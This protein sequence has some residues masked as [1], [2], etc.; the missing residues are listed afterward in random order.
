MTRSAIAI[1]IALVCGRAGAQDVYFVPFDID[2]PIQVDAD[3]TDWQGMP[4]PIALS[5][6]ANVTYRKRVWSGAA[7]LSGVVRLAYVHDGLLLAAEVTDD[8]VLQPGAGE[9]MWRADHIMI[10]LDMAPTAEPERELPGEGQYQVAISPGNFDGE[11]GGDA[12]VAP[13]VWVYR[14]EGLEQTGGLA[15]SRRTEG[16]YVVEAYVPFALLGLPPVA[17][18]D[19]ATFEIAI[20]DSDDPEEAQQLMV[21][22]STE[23][24]AI[25]RAR[26]LPLV[27]GDGNGEGEPPTTSVPLADEIVLQQRETAQVSFDA[28]DL[29]EGR[30]PFLFFHARRNSDQVGGYSTKALE[31]AVNGTVVDSDRLS[32]GPD[33]VQ[34]KDGRMLTWVTPDGRLTLPWAAD[35]TSTQEHETYGLVETTAGEYELYIGGLLQAGENT[36]EFRNVCIEIEPERDILTIGDVAVRAKP[37]APGLALLRPAPTG[38]LPVR[39]P[40]TE[41]PKTYELARQDEAEIE[42]SV[43]GDSFVVGSHFSAPDGQWHEGSTEFFE[44]TR[45]VIEHDEW[46]EVQDTFRNLTGENLPVM[47]E[48]SCA[49]GDRA[50]GVWLAGAR[51]PIGVGQRRRGD[52]PSVFAATAESG[53]GIVPLSDVLRVHARQEARDGTVTL[54]DRSLYL[55]PGAEYTAE[56]AIVPVPTPDFYDFINQARRMLDVNF[57]LEWLFAFHFYLEAVYDWSDET[58]RSFIINKSTNFIVK[59]LYGAGRLEGGGVKRGTLWMESDLQPYVDFHRRVHE[60]FPDGSVNTG[61]YFHCFL[62]VDPRSEERFTDDRLLDP[63]GNH[64]A[65]GEGRSAYMKYYV[66][67]L[68]SEFGAEMERW[69]DTIMHDIGVDGVYWDEFAYTRGYAYNMPDGCTADIDPQTMRITRLKGDTVLLSRDW[70]LKQVR[71]IMGEGRPFIVNGMP[72]TRTIAAEHFQAFTETGNIGNCRNTLL[73]SPVALGDHLS[74]RNFEDAYAV[75]LRALD[76]GCLYAWYNSN[77]VPPAPTLTEH[78]FPFTPIELHEGYVIGEERILTNRSGLFGWADDSRF[79]AY[80]YDRDGRATEEYPVTRVERDGRAYAEVRIPEGYSAAIVRAR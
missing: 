59:S 3:L 8:V 30:E 45:R 67:T 47:Q 36:I 80:V 10:W 39:E 29:P 53:L 6:A 68:G 52:N 16:G 57:T 79:E 77:V 55:E 24:W 31:V 56:W 1:S 78:M 32:S 2:P 73:Y 62:D 12:P 35:F 48:H 44:H 64:V 21:T 70:R 63:A 40:R 41:F 19:Y 58:L 9:D 74:E 72:R 7:D 22:R 43:G 20:S 14:P 71:R 69:L 60:L 46:I 37:N 28:G 18:N 11:A 34:M 26:F 38:E 4:N 17:M 50:T 33:T 65:Y 13:E 15:A 25:S 54:A 27:F 42:L 23:P 5:E 66:P 75:M 61:I 76:F 49:L 51:M